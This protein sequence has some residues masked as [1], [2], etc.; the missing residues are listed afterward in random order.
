MTMLKPF[1]SKSMENNGQDSTA[2]SMPKGSSVAV[3]KSGVVM[4]SI[5]QTKNHGQFSHNTSEESNVNDAAAK[6]QSSASRKKMAPPV[7][8]AKKKKGWQ[9]AKKQT[10]THT[11]KQMTTVAMMPI[12]KPNN[13]PES[14]NN[15]PSAD[16]LPASAV[17][18]LKMEEDGAFDAGYDSD[19][20]L[21]PHRGTDLHELAA[22]REETLLA[23]KEVVPVLNPYDN[24][25]VTTDALQ[26]VPISDFRR[27]P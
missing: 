24:N 23:N 1:L 22:L 20:S 6:K 14:K 12:M 18:L 25:D 8:P 21:G 13:T 10:I 9:S 2:K 4:Q 11:T 3:R 17:N 19:D 16:V 27:R 26:H 7:K 5:W 15:I